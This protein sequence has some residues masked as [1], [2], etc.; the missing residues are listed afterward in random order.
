MNVSIWL[1]CILY[2]QT[3]RIRSTP[4]FLA[5]QRKAE[6][7]NLQFVSSLTCFLPF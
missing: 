4:G 6:S 5:G 7:L 1:C 3:K 2:E